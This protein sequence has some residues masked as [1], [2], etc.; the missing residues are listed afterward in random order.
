[1]MTTHYLLICALFCAK[2]PAHE[3]RKWWIERKDK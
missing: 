3:I 1:M 2:L